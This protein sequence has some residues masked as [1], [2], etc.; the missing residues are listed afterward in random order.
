MADHGSN[1]RRV[2]FVG[3]TFCA[4]ALLGAACSAPSTVAGEA[5]KGDDRGTALEAEG[6]PHLG[7]T[8]VVAVTSESN[9][10][11][12]N[13]NQW[14][15][16]G[17]LEGAAMIE[18]LFVM[19]ND[20]NAQPWLADHADPN[21]DFTQWDITLK[22]NITFQNGQ[23]LDSA[24]LKRNLDDFYQ[25]GL[26]SIVMKSA[27]DHVEVTGPLSVRVHLK[28]RWAQFPSELTTAWM[29]APA[30]LDRTDKGSSNPIGTGPFTFESW[31]QNKSLVAKKN[32]T[33]WR[34]DSAGNQLPYLDQ[35]EFRPIAENDTR[36]KAL[37]SGDVDIAQSAS[38]KIVDDLQGQDFTVLKDYTSER[39][40][41]MLNTQTSEVNA[42]NPFG[43]LHARQAL[44]Y[45]TD[46]DQVAGLVGNDVQVT[47]QGYRPDSK[48][49]LPEDQDGYPKPD[50]AKARAEIE[51]YKKET[52]ATELKFTLSG[53]ATIENQTLMQSLQAQWKQ[54]GIDA[55]IDPLDQV[56][57]ISIAALGDYQAAWFRWYG[58]ANPDT[59]YYYDAKEDANPNGTLSV[60]FTHYTT[61]SLQQNLLKDRENTDFA[62]RK[63]GNDA[64]IKE[65]NDQAINIWLF[66]TPYSIISNP[67]VKGLND[68]R[69]HAFGNYT[70]KPW[71]SDVWLQG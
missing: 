1:V 4:V 19:D 12:P 41:V 21:P 33:Y 56:K 55:S 2:P 65:V 15:D 70:G 60:N 18:P 30:M 57:Y 42:G 31:T 8:L 59:N 66:D 3:A 17:S 27:I 5:P 68:F 39:T 25:T 37:Q 64:V 53:L 46:P 22:P 7:G 69:T 36:E 9:G 61:D 43:N 28:S 20:G 16:A 67:K 40:F 62:T 58:F 26:T 32:P 23:P 51:E 35:I 29:L 6:S 13:I 63:A 14:A 49:G 47:T 10:W 54:V 38:A 45:A 50:Q 71:W 11:N 52:G 34:K 48:W 44:A 24:A